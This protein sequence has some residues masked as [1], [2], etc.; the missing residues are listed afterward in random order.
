MATHPGMAGVVF[1]R[2]MPGEQEGDFDALSRRHRYGG[3]DRAI[4]GSVGRRR[5]TR[6]GLRQRREAAFRGKRLPRVAPML[7]SRQHGD[8]V[9]ER[10]QSQRAEPG[11][12]RMLEPAGAGVTRPHQPADGRVGKL[13]VVAESRLRRLQHRP[14]RDHHLALAD[15]PRQQRGAVG[16]RWIGLRQ[17]AT[18]GSQTGPPCCPPA[19]SPAGRMPLNRAG[20]NSSSN[21]ISA[22]LPGMSENSI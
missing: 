21:C 13:A 2:I 3:C 19:A 12:L 10:R 6:A 20:S 14:R 18:P 16:G 7:G 4:D 15:G 8:I 1:V 9:G 5:R 22:R 11:R 17:A